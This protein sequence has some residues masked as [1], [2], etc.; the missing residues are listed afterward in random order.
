M[1]EFSELSPQ[2][3]QNVNR[4]LANRPPEDFGRDSKRF[5]NEATDFINENPSLRR[6]VEGGAP[7]GLSPERQE[8]FL[9]Q[10][11]QRVS[12]IQAGVSTQQ[13][14][15]LQARASISQDVTAQ[16]EAIEQQG[17][18]RKAE[19]RIQAQA[20][21][22]DLGIQGPVQAGVDPIVF[23]ST[24]ETIARQ[25]FIEKRLVETFRDPSTGRQIPV[26]ETVVVTSKVGEEPEVRKTT[27]QEEKFFKE[28]TSELVI[29]P[30]RTRFEKITEP[31]V[32]TAGKVNIRLRE[33]V[34]EPIGRGVGIV[35]GGLGGPTTLQE[36]RFNIVESTAFLEKKG[37]PSIISKGGEVISGA[38][39]SIVEDIKT[40]P[41]KQVALVGVGVGVGAGLELAGAGAAAIGPGTSTVFKGTTIAGGIVLTGLAA[42]Q[43]GTQVSLAKTPIEKGEVV[44]TSFKDLALLGLGARTGQ[45]LFK[46]ITITKPVRPIRTPTFQ[47]VSATVVKGGKQFKVG[48]FVITG[49]KAP[50]L[51]TIR[52]TRFRQLL[53]FKPKSIEI[54]PAV[55]FNIKTIA[56]VVGKEPFFVTEVIQ[57]KPSGKLI[58]ITGTSTDFS[59]L[60]AGT[61]LTKTEKFAF[62]RLF[63]G[64]LQ[65]RPISTKNIPR[66]FRTET[67]LSKSF[68][69][70]TDIAKITPRTKA[71]KLIEP[72]RRIQRTEAITETIPFLETKDVSALTSTT[73]FKDVTFPFARATGKTPTLRGTIVQI[74]KPFILDKPVDVGFKITGGSKTPLSKTFGQV[75]V[76]DT[77][78]ISLPK[79]SIKISP[80]PTTIITAPSTRTPSVFAGLGLFERTT[81]QATTTPR[82][83]SDALVSPTTTRFISNVLITPRAKQ[84]SI[85]SPSLKIGTKPIIDTREIT[86]TRQV[87]ELKSVLKIKSI[88]KQK[89]QT[90]QKQKQKQKQ[91]LKQKQLPS[92]LP[93][94]TPLP[95]PLPPPPV[96]PPGFF[97]P[98]PSGP[99]KGGLFGVQIRRGGRFFSIGQFRT[100]QQAIARGRRATEQSLA[101]TFKVTGKGGLPKS[102]PGFTTK[103]RKGETLFIEK[104]S[105]RLQRRGTSKEVEEILGIKKK[106][107]RK[108]K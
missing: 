35:S 4:I 29:L 26:T 33:S 81:S 25:P 32:S 97:F 16:R 5:L 36:A 98:R 99:K 64:K 89:Q 9:Q 40:K 103:T 52:T 24:G 90:K 75:Q 72:G 13:Q 107:R 87:P 77:K 58:K 31:I 48:E 22:Q 2:A 108:K 88:V 41:L 15:E 76:F 70:T 60:R 28:Q 105:R 49:E 53:G 38:G 11:Q 14:A 42:K 6:Q 19:L 92:V 61:T 78:T 84:I 71:F 74:K 62:Q 45:K 27:A 69:E 65:G 83:I 3:Q 46:P 91:L 106:K 68:I 104:R 1:V 80:T 10:E 93:I 102:I 95:K 12:Q 85:T 56:P 37:V 43:I 96:P 21:Q 23:A 20:Q 44:G 101:A 50:P 86:S 57:G 54:T 100:Q 17:E 7:T 47:E 82:V 51:A 30:T 34:T 94:T 66:V 55:K 8:A 79:P 73:K 18:A 39:I 63:E 59:K 67:D